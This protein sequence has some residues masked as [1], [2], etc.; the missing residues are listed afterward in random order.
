MKITADA[1]LTT[2]GQIT[3]PKEIR[4][5]LS[6][7]AGTTMEFVLD[8][9]GN[10]TVRPKTPSMDRLRAV[11]EQ[12]SKHDVDLEAMRAES[13]RAWHSHRDETESA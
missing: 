2:K 1:T 8:E 6:I 11:Q 4:E 3:I 9:D 5:T 12:L 10:L 13:K 7:D